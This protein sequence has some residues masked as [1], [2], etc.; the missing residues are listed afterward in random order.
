MAGKAT[1]TDQRAG[2]Q[3]QQGQLIAMKVRMTEQLVGININTK[4]TYHKY[5]KYIV[6]LNDLIIHV[7]G[8]NLVLLI[9]GNDTV[10]LLL[11]FLV[12]RPDDVRAG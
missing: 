5:T 11:S 7:S 10:D 9:D 8:S 12:P 4:Q 2:G 3:Q 1:I 6:H